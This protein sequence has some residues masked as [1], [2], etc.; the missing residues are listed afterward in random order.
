[1][2][3]IFFLKI[4]RHTFIYL[5]ILNSFKDEIIKSIFL[6]LNVDYISEIVTIMMYFLQTNKILIFSEFDY[7]IND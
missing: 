4:L 7:Q 6:S 5:N 1:M 3:S 2:K